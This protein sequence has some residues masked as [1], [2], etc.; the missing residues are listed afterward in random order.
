[1]ALYLSMGPSG[2]GKDTLLLGAREALQAAGDDRV[3]FVTRRLTRSADAITDIE[4]SVTHAQFEAAEAAGEHAFSWAAHDTRYAI[5]AA[6]L[7]AALANN[8]RCL[9]NTS[10]TMVDA[11][12]QY[13]AQRGI[14]V[15]C[16]Y[17]TCSEDFL[18]ERLLARGREDAEAVDK[19]LARS[20]A[21][22]PTGPHVLTI[23]NEG[24]VEEGVD[25][26]RRCL[27]GEEEAIEAAKARTAAAAASAAAAGAHEAAATRRVR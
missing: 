15:Y 19:R 7:D 21:I 4:E 16:L 27:L 9:L 17:I 5:P 2:A 6:A 24:T 23:P 20:R 12:L 11:A 1:M 22:Q 14:D 25:V 10:R 26:V 3:V 8:Q 13:G 18:R